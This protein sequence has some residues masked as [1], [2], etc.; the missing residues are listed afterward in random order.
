MY[1]K[2]Q[3]SDETILAVWKK[4]K[5]VGDNDPNVYRKDACSAW[6]QFSKHGDRDAKYGW[7]IDHI[8]PEVHGGSDALSNL[9]PLHWKNNVEKGDSPQ[10]KCAVRN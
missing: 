2:E 9:Q 7:E 4:G 3:W 6:M 10:L 5:I 8:T 1:K